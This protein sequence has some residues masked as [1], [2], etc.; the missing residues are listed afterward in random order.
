MFLFL[1]SQLWHINTS[2]ENPTKYT[3]V[4]TDDKMM[5]DMN[6]IISHYKNLRNKS[7]TKCNF[8]E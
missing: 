1:P 3:L 2:M 7:K 5:P 6:G 4:I 8:I